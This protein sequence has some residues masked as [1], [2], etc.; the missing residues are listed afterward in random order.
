MLASFS[1]QCTPSIVF[2]S[3]TTISR[4]K[5]TKCILASIHKF[6][7]VMQCRNLTGI[8]SLPTCINGLHMHVPRHNFPCTADQNPLG[9]KVFFLFA[10]TP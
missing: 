6:L 7:A 10:A 2:I 4:E 8:T 3:F 5:D 1:I 9:N